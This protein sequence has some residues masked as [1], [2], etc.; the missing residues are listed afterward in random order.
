MTD[1]TYKKTILVVEDED[2]FLRP[3]S[4]KLAGEGFAVLA[5]HDGVEGLTLAREQK[6][7]MI[8]LDLKMPRM[9][10]MAMLRKLR[11]SEFGKTVPVLILTVL[12]INDD[13]R[14]RDVAELAPTYYVEKGEASLTEVVEKIREVLNPVEH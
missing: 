2:T 13:T 4:A 9:D 8:L 3:L 14:I 12:S 1:N 6:P 11:E 7:D 10:G 5:A